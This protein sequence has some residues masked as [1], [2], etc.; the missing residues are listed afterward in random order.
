MRRVDVIEL[1]KISGHFPEDR[2]MR[3]VSG[4]G[5]PTSAGNDSPS[6]AD[7]TSIDASRLQLE[8]VRDT[9]LRPL[10]EQ[11]ERQQATIAKQAET[12]GDLR[13]RAEVAESRLSALEASTT[14]QAD[15]DA[16]GAPQDIMRDIPGTPRGV[17]AAELRAV[18]RE[19]EY[20]ESVQGSAR[21]LFAVPIFIVLSAVL[22]TL[23]ALGSSVWQ[24]TQNGVT[25]ALDWFTWNRVGQL[26]VLSTALS[27]PI[28]IALGIWEYV[29]TRK[30]EPDS[31]ET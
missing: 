15:T 17:T 24:G 2:E 4:N 25:N 22:L 14:V 8:T 31:K 3:N 16:T 19:R 11:N 12:I 23:L 9:L 29:R 10:I 1:G 18:E 28:T 30:Q 6:S 13:R 26:A 27:L 7:I 21:L 20:R 5:S